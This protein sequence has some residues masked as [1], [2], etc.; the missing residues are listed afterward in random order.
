[1]EGVVTILINKCTVNCFWTKLFVLKGFSRCFP[2]VT[3]LL[4]T[5][6]QFVTLGW[7]SGELT[8][9]WNLWVGAR[10]GWSRRDVLVWS[11]DQREAA[12][13]LYGDV[14]MCFYGCGCQKILLH[15]CTSVVAWIELQHLPK[16]VF[17]SLCNF[18]VTLHLHYSC[19]LLLSIYK[20]TYIVCKD[21]RPWL[22]WIT[23]RWN[24]SIKVFFHTVEISVPGE[25][26][27]RI[28][29]HLNLHVITEISITSSKKN[30]KTY[31][32]RTQLGL[33][34]ICFKV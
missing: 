9:R 34:L 14:R 24:I 11:V 32:G 5:C 30:V 3:T 29:L 25:D 4:L 18:G 15:W 27:E 6:L 1:M 2:F 33:N 22:Y 21:L 16:P 7:I 10:A 12:L 31:S 26:D 8:V 19:V 28:P 17:K 13:T 23:D 20:Y